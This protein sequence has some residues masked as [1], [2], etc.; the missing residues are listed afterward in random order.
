MSRI[1]KIL[2]AILSGQKDKNL[3]F[4]D[5]QSI[6][7]KLGFTERVKGDHHIFTKNG[8]DEIINIQPIR[9]MAKPY[10]VKQVRNIILKYKFGLE[11]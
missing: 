8:V 1:H 6:L 11:E 5:L 4:S 2:L 9:N 3:Y 10:Q 7:F